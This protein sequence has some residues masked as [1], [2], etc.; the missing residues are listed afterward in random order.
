[1]L[2]V[3]WISNYLYIFVNLNVVFIFVIDHGLRRRLG[4]N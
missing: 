3:E 4:E 2:C 1:M